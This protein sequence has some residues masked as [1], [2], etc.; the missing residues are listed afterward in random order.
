ML[1]MGI[2]AP[3]LAQAEVSAT[4]SSAAA[5]AA[6]APGWCIQTAL[7]PGHCQSIPCPS[8]KF[9][10]PI[11]VDAAAPVS[12]SATQVGA[13]P[14]SARFFCAPDVQ[15]ICQVISLI[16]SINHVHCPPMGVGTPAPAAL[17]ATNQA[18]APAAP[19]FY[20]SPAAQVLCQVVGVLCTLKHFT[21]PTAVAAS[22]VTSSATIRPTS[23]IRP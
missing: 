23:S 8:T 19:T 1:A 16:C 18:A 21:C 13:A 6:V 14:A 22:A 7:N 9:C 12:L 4:A 5:T 20:C 2:A 17:S 11:G 3:T 15:V 10:P